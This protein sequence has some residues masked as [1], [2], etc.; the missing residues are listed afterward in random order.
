LDKI[1]THAEFGRSF[2]EW[3][4]CALMGQYVYSD[5]RRR[6]RQQCSSN[7]DDDDD[8]IDDDDVGVVRLT[9]RRVHEWYGMAYGA[10][11]THMR[12][13][14]RMHVRRQKTLCVNVVRECL[15]YLLRHE[16]PLDDN[17]NRLFDVSQLE[18]FTRVSM[19]RVRSLV[20]EYGWNILFQDTYGL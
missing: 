13:W 8:N 11:V 3:L 17:V 14:V 5:D 9:D 16:P 7:D 4:T 20:N 18:F 19:N 1:E 15:I 2:F 6:R 12:D 10:I